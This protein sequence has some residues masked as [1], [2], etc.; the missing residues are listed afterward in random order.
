MYSRDKIIRPYG[1]RF[2]IQ[3]SFHC[4]ICKC[5]YY[6]PVSLKN[7]NEL[8]DCLTIFIKMMVLINLWWFL[9]KTH[10]KYRDIVFTAVLFKL[11]E[12]S[13]DFLSTWNEKTLDIFVLVISCY[14]SNGQQ[15]WPTTWIHFT[16]TFNL[17][18][19][20]SE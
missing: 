11:E 17:L 18:A 12:Q 15:Q 6:T 13:F 8:H 3:T 5:T 2:L 16:P 1:V 10:K 14:M 19:C 9:V 20:Y 4:Y 7:Q